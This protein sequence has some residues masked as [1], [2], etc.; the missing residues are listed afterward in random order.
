[1]PNLN[2]IKEYSVEQF[3]EQQKRRIELLKTMLKHFDEGRSKSFYCIAA[4]LLSTTDLEKSLKS[5]EQKIKADKIGVGETK[6][7]SK[8]LKGL[9]N[10]IAAREGIELKLRRR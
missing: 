4:T 7:K 2:F 6:T 1:M 8:I 5:S 10:N 9:L 3:I